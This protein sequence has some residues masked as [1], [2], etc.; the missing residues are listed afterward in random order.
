MRFS[1]LFLPLLFAF[2]LLSVQQGSTAH[3]FSHLFAE[4]GQD[5]QTPHSQT[6]EKCAS[7]A[8]LGSALLAALHAFTPLVFAEAKL[9]R[10]FQPPHSQH[11][12]TASARGP[13]ASLQIA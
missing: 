3:A 7:Y 5:K 8:Q 11:A 12:L 6:C 13:P 1:R 4:Q 9:A 2:A 10:S